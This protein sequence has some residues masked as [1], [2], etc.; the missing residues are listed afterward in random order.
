MMEECRYE[1]QKKMMIWI[2][3]STVV[4]MLL[5]GCTHE[6]QDQNTTASFHGDEINIVFS[7]TASGN[8]PNGNGSFTSETDD[9]EKWKGSGTFED[10]TLTSGS[11]EDYPMTLTVGEVDYT[12]TYSGEIA[13]SAITGE[14]KYKGTSD[15]DDMISFDGTWKDGV[16]DAGSIKNLA[17]TIT[18]GE[19]DET[20]IYNGNQMVQGILL[21]IRQDFPTMANGLPVKC[22]EVEA[23][24]ICLIHL[25]LQR[26]H[27]MVF[28]METRSTEN[29]TEKVYSHMTKKMPQ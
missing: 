18:A 7:G 8:T 21:M 16:P 27:T 13:D 17:Y 29:L 19:T 9:G 4:A 11:I 15:D 1:E 22:P 23:L 20:G 6:I 24:K 25:P 26:Q 2:G 28:I 14:G 3:S 10:G 5:A 12:G